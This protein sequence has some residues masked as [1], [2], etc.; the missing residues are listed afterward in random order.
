M[1]VSLGLGHQRPLDSRCGDMIIIPYRGGNGQVE[2]ATRHA[3][4]TDHQ[5]HHAAHVTI[6]QLVITE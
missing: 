4:L 3:T 2:M 6:D 5:G 1:G